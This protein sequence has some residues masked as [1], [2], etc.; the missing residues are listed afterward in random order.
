[1][2]ALIASVLLALYVFVPYILFHRFCSLFIRLKK[3]QRTKTEEIAFGI[4]LAVLP[5]VLTLLLCWSGWINGSV[6][7][8]PLVDSPQQKAGDYQTVFAAAYSENFFKEHQT[9][10]WDAIERVSQRQANFLTWNY[11]L[12]L[13]EAIGFV[14]LTS[15]YGRLQKF[16]P[17]AWFAARFLLPAVSEWHVLLTDFS[18][19]PGEHRS[20]QVDV[21]T[22]D[23]ILYRGN[24]ADYFIGSVGELSGLLLKSAQRFQRDKLED[25]RK[26]GKAKESGDY[27]R[28]IAGDGNFY[29][30]DD[31]IASLNIRYPL[32]PTR[33][34]QIVQDAV[35]KLALQGVSNVKVEVLEHCRCTNTRHG[36]E[37]PCKAPPTEN[38]GMC[39]PCHD[40]AALEFSGTEHTG[41][42]VNRRP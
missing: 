35:E 16:K 14:A 20:V 9:E 26:A 13:G 37:N 21:I 6:A 25:D 30:P 3:L 38:D 4:L 10:A 2:V 27:W 24:L 12:L 34:Q 33:Y 8:F 40:S 1:M 29:L 39:K 41:D 15:S 11:L 22:R 36:H 42:S 18:F 32:P 28:V 7:P 23:N 5:F 17:Y 19:P 31:N